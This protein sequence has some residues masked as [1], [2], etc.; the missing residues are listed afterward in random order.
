MGYWH[1]VKL[2]KLHTWQKQPNATFG[3]DIY[4]AAPVE[5]PKPQP[6]IIM[7]YLKHL[8]LHR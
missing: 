3:H 4:G 5:L 6:C 1:S 7:H 8:R 2:L